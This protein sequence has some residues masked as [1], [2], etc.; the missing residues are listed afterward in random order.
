MSDTDTTEDYV[1]VRVFPVEEHAQ[2]LFYPQPAEVWQKPDTSQLQ[3]SSKLRYILVSS[4]ICRCAYSPFDGIVT[5]TD[6]I[7]VPYFGITMPS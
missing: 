2:K 3:D 5:S 4:L 7:T 6:G 1:L